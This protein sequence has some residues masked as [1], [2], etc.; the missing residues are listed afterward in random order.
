MTDDATASL[1]R[2]D[3]YPDPA[4]SYQFVDGAARVSSVNDAFEATFPSFDPNRSLPGGFATTDRLDGSQLPSLETGGHF[5]CEL[6]APGDVTPTRYSGQVVAPTADELGY[7]LFIEATR[8][9]GLE[10]DHVA[11][12]V[13]HDLRNPLDVAKERLRA[14]RELDED[15]HFEHVERAHQ[16]M[17]RIIDDVLTLARGDEF[18]EPEGS[19]DLED[20]VAAAWE[21]VETADAT[22]TVEPGLP[23]VT[24]DDDRL[25][26]LF[27]NL[28]R[29]AIEH[30]GRDVTVRVGSLSNA[31]RGVFVADDGAGFVTDDLDAV[32]APGFST[33]EHGTGLGL[34]IVE[35]IATS[36][37]WT[38]G[39]TESAD[40][41]ARFEITG[42]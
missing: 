36:H 21:T 4:L 7:I 34:A 33:N 11:S 25:R 2:L 37:G 23:R 27:E 16:R 24:A 6:T 17:E 31:E 39:V 38:V 19:V 42:L 8:E 18:V 28:F 40:G 29:N 20:L 14:G 15:E 30:G 26:R 10:L 32:F 12:V 5:S 35:R 13:S 3:R 22:I 1:P 9:T 41:G